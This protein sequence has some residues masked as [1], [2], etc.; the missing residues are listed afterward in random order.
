MGNIERS[1]VIIR[2]NLFGHWGILKKMNRL[3]HGF[4]IVLLVSAMTMYVQPVRTGVIIIF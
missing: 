4:L 3:G 2:P 1:C